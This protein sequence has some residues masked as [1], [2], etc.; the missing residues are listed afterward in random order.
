MT[1]ALLLPST[2]MVQGSERIEVSLSAIPHF[3]HVF[4][5]AF[6]GREKQETPTW[7]NGLPNGSTKCQ[8]RMLDER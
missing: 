6:I 5:H 8:T 7:A 3:A 1:R 4:F 2:P